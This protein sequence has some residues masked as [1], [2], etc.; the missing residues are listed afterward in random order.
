MTPLPE[1]DQP[2]CARDKRTGLREG[3]QV[4]IQLVGVRERQSVGRTLVDLQLTAGYE[5]HCLACCRFEWRRSVVVAMYEQGRYR[6]LSQFRTKVGFRVH[7]VKVE[8]NLQRTSVHNHTHPP[9]QNF[10]RYVVLGRTKEA[11]GRSS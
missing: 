3:Q 8:H 4:C 10:L 9:V 11:R 7:F 5:W 6:D 2:S 1:L